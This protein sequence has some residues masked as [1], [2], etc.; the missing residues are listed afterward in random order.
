MKMYSASLCTVFF[1]FIVRHNRTLPSYCV[2]PYHSTPYEVNKFISFPCS[3]I[4]HT[5]LPSVTRV[6][7]EKH[8]IQTHFEPSFTPSSSPIL[9]K[10]NRD[11]QTRYGG[12]NH[13]WLCGDGT[14]THLESGER[15]LLLPV[16]PAYGGYF[17]VSQVYMST[18]STAHNKRNTLRW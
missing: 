7:N 5:K 9:R 12:C 2:P 3:I 15:Q 4:I 11:T 13:Y 18:E 10:T 8:H 6:P 16:L 14:H 1:N 17:D